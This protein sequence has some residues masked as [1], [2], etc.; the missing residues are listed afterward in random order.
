MNRNLDVCIGSK[1]PK[2]LWL[3]NTSLIR[4]NEKANTHLDT[5]M[6][7]KK[8]KSTN[9]YTQPKCKTECEIQPDRQLLINGVDYTR[10]D[11][12]YFSGWPQESYYYG[13][14]ILIV[15]LM[16]FYIRELFFFFEYYR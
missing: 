11:F 7:M 1:C 8:L 16:F 9:N 10:D 12:K 5:Y 14:I 13:S 3:L 15:L 6:S 4:F 2:G